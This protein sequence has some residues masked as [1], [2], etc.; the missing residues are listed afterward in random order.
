M[1][2]F[3]VERTRILSRDEELRLLAACTGERTKAV[4]RRRLGKLERFDQ[5][6]NMDNPQLRAVIILAIETAM[7]RGEIH[8]LKW[9]A[10]DLTGRTIRI[11]GA[12]TKTLKTRLVPISARLRETLAQLRQNQLRPNS[13]VFGGADFKRS[14][15][16]AARNA[17][18]S[19]IHFHDLR[20]TAITRMLEAGISPPLVMKISGHTQQK[21]FMRYVNQSESS[22]YEIALKLDAAA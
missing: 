19:D 10:V 5:T 22:V 2:S 1:D 21:T 11:E 15:N 8:A 14:F 4:E 6:V 9:S 20:H 7:R 18:L 12:S 17:G 16:T 3:E 13:P